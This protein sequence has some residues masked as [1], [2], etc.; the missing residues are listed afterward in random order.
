MY[1]I[2]YHI[3]GNNKK[4]PTIVHLDRRAF[5]ISDHPVFLSTC[6]FCSSRIFLIWLNIGTGMLRDEN[7][8]SFVIST[9]IFEVQ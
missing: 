7:D 5:V 9:C 3:Q 8:T 4:F 6:K 2:I 1:S